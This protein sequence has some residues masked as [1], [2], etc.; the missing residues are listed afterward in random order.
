MTGFTCT[1]TTAKEENQRSTKL[2]FKGEAVQRKYE[3]LDE[4]M[5]DGV[6]HTRYYRESTLYGTIDGDKFTGHNEVYGHAKIEASGDY[7]I[8]GN[9]TSYTTWNQREGSFYGH[10]KVK[11]FM[12]I[13][14]SAGDFN[15]KSVM[16]GAGDFNGWKQFSIS[17]SIEEGRYGVSGTVLIPN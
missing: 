11:G 2:F 16:R 10:F 8:N 3:I 9:V 1:F 6:I 4:W 5:E 13:I 14:P 17:W 12:V 15:G 7:T